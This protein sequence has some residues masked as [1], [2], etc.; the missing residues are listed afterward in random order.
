MVGGKPRIFNIFPNRHQPKESGNK[1]ARIPQ[2]Q[3]TYQQK[4]QS[5]KWNT[6]PPSTLSEL[7]TQPAAFVHLLFLTRFQHLFSTKAVFCWKHNQNCVVSGAQLLCITDIEN[8]LKHQLQEP[9]FS[10][11][12]PD[13]A[14]TFP[15]EHTT[16][17]GVSRGFIGPQQKSKVI[18]VARC[19]SPLS[20]S[21]ILS[22][23]SQIVFWHALK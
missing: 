18:C 7:E 15:T 21:L 8:K 19:F 20:L 11:R 17:H 3:T 23:R 16:F 1:K 4:Q 10:R 22:L 12:V 2:I 9:K 6:T 13:L 14:F 5:N